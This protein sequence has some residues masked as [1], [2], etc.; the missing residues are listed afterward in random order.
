MEFMN[1]IG[2]LIQ[3]VVGIKRRRKRS[4]STSDR[5]ASLESTGSEVDGIPVVDEEDLGVGVQPLV[6]KDG[7]IFAYTGVRLGHP[8]GIILTQ[9][10]D[11]RHKRQH[12]AAE[13]RST[14]KLLRGSQ[15]P[16]AA[17]THPRRSTSPTPAQ[18]ERIPLPPAPKQHVPRSQHPESEVKPDASQDE[19][20]EALVQKH[21]WD[22]WPEGDWA[23]DYPLEMVTEF[24]L[25]VNWAFETLGSSKGDTSA[26]S[27]PDGKLTRRRCLGYAKC[28]NGN[29]KI[30][31][32]PL[33]KKP[34]RE[35]QMRAG[36]ACGA[37]LQWHQ[38][39]KISRYWIY[40]DGVHYENTSHGHPHPP[41]EKR[42]TPAQTVDFTN[43]VRDY[44]T[45]GPAQL[46]AGRPGVGGPGPSVSTI[47]PLLLNQQR[48]AYEKRKAIDK[49]Q[50]GIKTQ[51]KHFEP[52]MAKFRAAHPSWTIN[53][54][55]NRDFKVVVLQ[56]PFMR[57]RSVKGHIEEDALN[58]V[59]SD[60]AHNYFK[61]DKNYLIVSSAYEPEFLKS[62][63]PLVMTFS[64][65]A[66]SKHYLLHFR[67]L[68][69]GIEEEYR[70]RH[71]GKPIPSYLIANVL[72]FSE[73]ER[74][75]LLDAL[76]EFLFR[77]PDNNRTQTELRQDA[78]GL[79][80]GCERHF[81]EQVER[82]SKISHVITPTQRPHFQNRV[83]ELLSCATGNIFRQKAAEIIEDFPRVKPWL[84]WW[85]RP[86]HASMLFRSEL[87]MD[88]SLFFDL[89]AT[90]NAEEA[91]HHRLYSMIKRGNNMFEGLEGLVRAAE[92]LEEKYLHAKHGG[93]I[94][95]GSDPRHWKATSNIYGRTH[96]SRGHVST[97][98]ERADA[99][100][101]DR[102]ADLVPETLHASSHRQPAPVSNSKLT[103][104]LSYP[105]F[106]NSCWL[107]SGLTALFAVAARDSTALEKHLASLPD[108]QPLNWLLRVL[109]RHV[110]EAG[111]DQLTS[112]ELA[113]ARND[114]RR[115]MVL[116]PIIIGL[117]SEEQWYTPFGWLWEA[118]THHVAMKADNAES[119]PLARAIN[120][121]RVQAVL[122]RM[123]Y[124]DPDSPTHAQTHWLVDTPAARNEIQLLN[125]QF[126]QFNG[127][128]TKWFNQGFLNS[129][130][131]E[132]GKC[133]RSV[134]GEYLCGGITI[135]HS[136]V[137]S[138][139]LIFVIEVVEPD[140]YDWHIP[141]ELHPFPDT[142]QSKLSSAGVR[143]ELISHIYTNGSHFMTRYLSPNGRIFDYDG[144]KNGGRAIQVS[145]SVQRHMTG[146]FSKLKGIP[147][148]Y[149]ISGLV[150]R[151]VGGEPA[152]RL[153][154][155]ER[156]K[157]WTN[158]LHCTF[159]PESETFIK[160][161]FPQSD[162]LRLDNTERVWH[163]GR[164]LVRYSEYT[165]N[166]QQSE[167][168]PS[169]P[170]KSKKQ[171][172]GDAS[173]DEEELSAPSDPESE[174]YSV[175]PDD[176]P[177]PA[178]SSDEAD[179][180]LGRD[181]IDEAWGQISCICG[182][183]AD[184][185]PSDA[186]RRLIQ[187]EVCQNWSHRRCLSSIITDWTQAQFKLL[188]HVCAESRPAAFV[189]PGQVRLQRQNLTTP[190][191]ETLWA[192][193]ECLGF[194]INRYQMEY[195]W[196]WLPQVEWVDGGDPPKESFY[197]PYDDVHMTA[198][199]EIA[200]IARLRV[201]LTLKPAQ[202]D[203][204]TLN[205]ALSLV[206]ALATPQIVDI[207]NTQPPSHPVALDFD[208]DHANMPDGID[209]DERWLERHGIVSSG[210]DPG[211]WATFDDPIHILARQRQA[212]QV[213]GSWE[214]ALTMAV[215]LWISL[216]IQ[217]SLGEDW[218]LSGNTY[219]ELRS[220]GLYEDWDFKRLRRA[221]SEM[222]NMSIGS[223]DA[224]LS[225]VRWTQST[226][227]VFFDRS[228]VYRGLITADRS[229]TPLVY[230]G[231]LVLR[232]SDLPD[233]EGHN[234]LAKKR[235]RFDLPPAHADMDSGTGAKMKPG[236]ATRRRADSSEAVDNEPPQKRR[237]Q[238]RAT[239]PDAAP[240][241]PPAPSANT[242]AA[243]K[244]GRRGRKKRDPM[245]WDMLVGG[246]RMT[247]YEYAAAFPT[248]FEENGPFHQYAQYLK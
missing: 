186:P 37:E 88:T 3:Q 6:G 136:Y 66:T 227:V 38:C 45:A 213:S 211:L 176:E 61:G 71:P 86:E 115:Q 198:A 240:T 207:V 49:L 183:D 31:V 167:L 246:K 152:Q 94:Y 26:E 194:D 11:S 130:S 117:T 110:S 74:N 165:E 196:R 7:K 18:R 19:R 182:S 75:G 25:R 35:R 203:K 62:Y 14:D 231:L 146:A 28:N 197:R 141:A 53:V 114:F 46:L 215:T 193:A 93:K 174:A 218:D 12:V 116:S 214:R 142:K 123:C 13:N 179:S 16:S 153:F 44:P 217:H 200:Q 243:A 188:C 212:G 201:P 40:R 122:L 121:F 135:S 9:A 139:P 76:V 158:G 42:L 98:A 126:E 83:H 128:I 219:L 138:I 22:F 157:K 91:M 36:C 131:W 102:A 127:K 47:N 170:R 34:A 225:Q 51:D 97:A 81:R 65:G 119:A 20:L 226:E 236:D 235:A 191:A 82:V 224:V 137:L 90:T 103:Y 32:R 112:P 238:A 79:V 118:T 58:G 77:Q 2:R 181:E 164:Q 64:H 244:S 216:C 5:S 57:R 208:E 48:T 210:L 78:Q 101:P 187:C 41:N 55:Y 192:A 234:N 100:P 150:Y 223:Y 67:Q 27:F 242:T 147:P 72:D 205:H 73:A 156:K 15:L 105:W 56:S 92:L 162:H 220:G 129:G 8:A 133:W 85:M 4:D 175:Q 108:N 148:N 144:M 190:P 180:R 161:G 111:N 68:L 106:N 50:P 228:L 155:A 237:R 209:L 166:P 109:R 149:E 59:V 168:P 54:H 87:A 195:L 52:E 199:L 104:Q 1:S 159:D 132:D 232:E 10:A 120:L 204:D 80:K 107:D 241:A 89:P 169:K 143:Y 140:Q 113:S 23:A 30:I 43:F 124:G 222:K 39:G 189:V 17:S 163:Q 84:L 202:A 63:V 221:I 248:Q 21:N 245:D 33:T 185:E 95:Y 96:H 134:D 184:E 60:A 99:R 173:E 233:I 69:K 206:C 24:N 70:L 239:G 247:A 229:S 125:H 154:R 172:R 29:C 177:A 151:L 178:S 230:N 145:G 171:S 160:A